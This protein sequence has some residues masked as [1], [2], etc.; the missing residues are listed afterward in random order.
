VEGHL[1]YSSPCR[2][3][4]GLS[5]KHSIRIFPSLLEAD[6]QPSTSCP[7]RKDPHLLPIIVVFF[8]TELSCPRLLN[9]VFPLRTK[10]PTWAAFFP[11]PPLSCLPFECFPMRVLNE[12]LG[13][14]CNFFQGCSPFVRRFPQDWPLFC[15]RRRPT[16]RCNVQRSPFFLSLRNLIFLIF[17][18]VCDQ[19]T[20]LPPCSRPS[21]GSDESPPCDGGGV[22]PGGALDPFSRVGLERQSNIAVLSFLPGLFFA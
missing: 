21:Q 16:H 6:P 8:S 20:A 7:D 4:T 18:P 5:S 10:V 9:T 1:R 12:V 13:A 22:N 3:R 15:I 2:Q 19:V 17:F 14:G 11:P